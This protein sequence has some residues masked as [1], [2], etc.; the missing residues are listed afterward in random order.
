M[1]E[2]VEQIS[3]ADQE[4]DFLKSNTSLGL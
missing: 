3:L 1:F 2:N 4:D